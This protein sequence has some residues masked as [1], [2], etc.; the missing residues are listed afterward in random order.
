MKQLYDY[1]EDCGCGNS[2]CNGGWFY[3]NG[4]EYP[5]SHRQEQSDRTPMDLQFGPEDNEEDK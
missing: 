5:C 4:T 3:W 2:R 1:T